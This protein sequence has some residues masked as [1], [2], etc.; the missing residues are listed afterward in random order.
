MFGEQH[1]SEFARFVAGRRV[2][3]CEALPENVERARIRAE[4]M[5]DDRD[6]ADE[7]RCPHCL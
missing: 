1:A 6:R 2:V 3:L 4:R 5:A 7:D